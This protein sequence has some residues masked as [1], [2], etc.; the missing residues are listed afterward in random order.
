MYDD[1][2]RY[3]TA[4]D[5]TASELIRDAME[6]YRQRWMLRRT[7]LADLNPVSVGHVLKPLD[8]DDDLLGEMLAHGRS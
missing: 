3:A 8:E 7:T 4:Q 5:R 2:R 1:F 6:E